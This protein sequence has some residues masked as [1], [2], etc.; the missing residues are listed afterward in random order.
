MAV[1]AALK[2]DDFSAV[3]IPAGEA[4]GGH[5][6]FGAGVDEADHFHF[7]NLVAEEFGELGFEAGVGAKGHA[8]GGGALD[9]IDDLFA[10]VAEDE[11]P[12]GAAEVDELGAVFGLDGGAFAGGEIYGG[13]ADTVEGADGA[14]DAAGDNGFGSFKPVC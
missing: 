6:R 10:G 7:G 4:D 1:V 9:N 5:D 3:C 2:F 12:P 13:S 14:V 8:V 11:W